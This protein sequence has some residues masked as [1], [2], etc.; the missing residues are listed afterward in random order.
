M[1]A[2][3]RG[4]EPPRLKPIRDKYTLQW[5][6]HYGGGRGEKPKD[7]RWGEFHKNLRQVFFGL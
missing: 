6:A 7:R 1:H 2:V 3:D 5:V 4:P